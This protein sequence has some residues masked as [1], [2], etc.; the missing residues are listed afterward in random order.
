MV[1]EGGSGIATTFTSYGSFLA[2]RR[3]RHGPGQLAQP[4]LK[5]LEEFYAKLLQYWGLTVD[6]G[7]V[8]AGFGPQR[9]ED[10]D[11]VIAGLAKFDTVDQ[12]DRILE[13]FHLRKLLAGLFRNRDLEMYWLRAPNEGLQGF[14]PLHV[15]L[16]GS[17]SDVL[18]VRQF[19]ETL[20]G[21]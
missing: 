5:G 19:L 8:L 20:A 14:S 18:R 6:Q 16:Q 15:L 10:L 2:H 7:A 1:S 11:R 4:S 9:V 17:F 3:M 12:R 21:V 13:L